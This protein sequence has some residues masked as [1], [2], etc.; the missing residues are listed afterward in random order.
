MMSTET[1]SGVQSVNRAI[2]LLRAVASTPAGQ[3][4]VPALARACG[5][6]RATAWRILK[7]LEGESMVALDPAGGYVIGL[8]VLGLAAGAGH[9]ALM[10][11]AHP[12]LAWA[13]R[14]SGE[15][16]ALAVPGSDGL[17][18]IDEV[19]PPAVVVASW[20]G[21]TVPMHA[22]STGKALLAFLPESQAAALAAA[23]LPRHTPTTITDSGALLDDLRHTRER[24]F[25]VCDGEL[26]STLLG[27]SA[28]VLDPAGR[29]VAII[30]LWGPAGRVCADD[31]DR[32]GATAVQAARRVAAVIAGA[33]AQPRR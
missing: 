20:L 23:G 14:R 2:A 22:T 5:L 33:G 28:P 15:T 25:A 31:F 7:T 13:S 8:G 27:V 9:S 1:R 3:A 12:E 19:I 32:H 10:I 21:R 11:A 16:A 24:G 26:E 17:T 18:Y 29:P 4:S 6:N 30:S